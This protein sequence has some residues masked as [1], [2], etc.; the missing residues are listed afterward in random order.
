M[1]RGAERRPAFPRFLNVAA[2]VFAELFV[3][4]AS[5]REG[6]H[7]EELDHRRRLKPTNQSEEDSLNSFTSIALPDRKS[8]D[9]LDP[10]RVK[11]LWLVVLDF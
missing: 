10:K 2:P 9:A 11:G 5:R 4:V 3:G 6:T 1:P 8:G 7:P